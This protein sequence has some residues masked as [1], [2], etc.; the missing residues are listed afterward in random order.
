MYDIP[1]RI[2]FLTN[3]SYLTTNDMALAALFVHLETNIYH[4]LA[5]I[6]DVSGLEKQ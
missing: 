1:N 6:C 5:Y 2:Y 3:E 4:I